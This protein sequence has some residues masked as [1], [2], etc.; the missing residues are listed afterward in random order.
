M[1]TAKVSLNQGFVILKLAAK[2][3]TGIYSIWI[4]PP[5]T[6]TGTTT[7]QRERLKCVN[8]ELI[9][10]E[11]ILL[12]SVPLKTALLM[13]HAFLK[14]SPVP[15]LLIDYYPQDSGIVLLTLFQRTGLVD[16]FHG[17]IV[18]FTMAYDL[19]NKYLPPKRISGEFRLSCLVKHHL[20]NVY[21]TRSYEMTYR[22]YAIEAL[23]MKLSSVSEIIE[24][25]R[26]YEEVFTRAM[27]NPN[28]YYIYRGLEPLLSAVPET[29]LKAMATDLLS[30]PILEKVF[31]EIGSVGLHDFL[32]DNWNVRR[33]LTAKD[34]K[35]LWN[36]VQ[37]F[38]KQY[39]FPSPAEPP[40]G[41]QD[42]TMDESSSS[43]INP[44][45]ALTQQLSSRKEEEIPI[46][47]HQ[48]HQ[49][50]FEQV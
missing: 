28:T 3:D 21:E 43:S 47:Q 22:L 1:I 12:P 6:M 13:F 16:L 27:Q 8:G 39:S 23:A 38:E 36:I 24:N 20:K 37:F 17:V 4:K 34:N 5:K 41:S 14:T 42:V 26:S 29:V 7:F 9:V 19:W 50:R 44:S 35:N 25:S 18:G 10:G 48:P 30:Y 32:S 31:Q 46:V 40:T 2:L 49:D 11:K 15:V 33:L 45:S